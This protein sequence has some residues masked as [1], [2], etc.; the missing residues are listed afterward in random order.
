MNEINSFITNK[1]LD[2]DLNE[3]SPSKFKE[4]SILNHKMLDIKLQLKESPKSKQSSNINNNGNL[5]T[6]IIGK[7]MPAE[8][9]SGAVKFFNLI[10]TNVKSNFVEEEIRSNKEI[11][12]STLQSKSKVSNQV[13]NTMIKSF[14]ERFH[15]T[16]EQLQVVRDK[17]KEGC[18]KINYQK[19]IDFDEI[20]FCIK[21]Q[22]ETTYK[23]LK[24]KL[25]DP[26][27]KH[28]YY[29]EMRS[30]ELL[31]RMFKEGMGK[32][33]RE[34]IDTDH[35]YYVFDYNL[36]IEICSIHIEKKL[37]NEDKEESNKQLHNY[38]NSAIVNSLYPSSNAY[39][40]SY[41]AS[42]YGFHEEF[43]EL[44]NKEEKSFEDELKIFNNFQ[45]IE[46]I[47]AFSN[48]TTI[49]N[50][51]VGY[52]LKTNKENFSI[53]FYQLKQF[54]LE[55]EVLI[56]S[57]LQQR[58]EFLKF[59][60]EFW[61]KDLAKN[62][63]KWYSDFNLKQKISLSQQLD[64]KIGNIK[65]DSG[66]LFNVSQ[67]IVEFH[68]ISVDHS[69]ISSIISTWN[70][71]EHDRD[72]LN[73]LFSLK[74]YDQISILINS[75]KFKF[76][77]F[78]EE[79]FEE[80]IK[81]QQLN[82]IT[83]FLQKTS[84][85]NILNRSS[86]QEVIV[87]KYM[88]KGNTIYYGTEMLAKIYKNNWH[89]D[90]TK[91]LCKSILRTIKTKDIL[92]CHSPILTCVLLSE[93]LK[94]IGSISILNYSRID[95][96]VKELL[97]FCENIQYSSNDEAYI[98]FLMNQRSV[99]KRT[100]FQ[101][102]SDN[103]F[104]DCLKN[105]NIGTLVG[106]MWSGEISHNGLFK[107]SSLQRYLESNKL[108][109]TDPLIEFTPFDSTKAYFFQLSVWENSCSMRYFPESLFTLLLIINYNVFIYL[110][111]LDGRYQG[112]WHEV[113]DKVP[114]VKFF[115]YIYIIQTSCININTLMQICFAFIVGRKIKL[116]YWNLLE[117]ILLI[118]SFLLL[119]DAHQYESLKSI[120]DS[121]V[122]LLCINDVIVWLRI[123]GILLTF[124]NLG[125]VIRIIYLM[126]FLLLKYIFI[127][128]VF[129]VCMSA[130]FTAI[131]FGSSDDYRD[132]STTLIS[133]ST[134]FVNSFKTDSFVK[135]SLFGSIMVMFYAALSSML[136]LNLLIAV[137]S[138]VYDEISSQVDSSHRS[139]LISYYQKYKWDKRFGYMILLP[140]QV[141]SINFLVII[142]Q[143]IFGFKNK[144]KQV[145]F[146]KIVCKI[147][148]FVFYFVFI[149]IFFAIYTAILIPF[150]Y[151]K[152]L[153]S[154]IRFQFAFR[155]SQKTK[156]ELLL[157]TL[158]GGIFH[159]LYFYFRDLY[160]ISYYQ[161]QE[162]PEKATEL[163]RVKNQK[164]YLK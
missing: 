70:Y 58:T 109:K 116:N 33:V 94:N 98:K 51:V 7:G 133:L 139:V 36:I 80:V 6:K 113:K 47:K 160:L 28:F 146:N 39:L 93:V 71:L 135:N 77:E 96:V 44:V 42:Q 119:F 125:P 142:I 153:F 115:Y 145:K 128:C 68:K 129:I 18:K 21:I 62:L 100:A 107:A 23:E 92:N 134:P 30:S 144:D 102:S 27:F 37:L 118:T 123:V 132:F 81:S 88:K 103:N 114:E 97:Q 75:D 137:L 38:F 53:F 105:P 25:T 150:C 99:D 140:S 141:S 5:H 59:L 108:K 26:I 164:N 121:E 161:F 34:I 101:I 13:R 66:I 16:Q 110:L 155:G 43:K 156:I 122:V 106:K 76:W 48:N 152:A 112:D 159:L 14:Q 61:N 117:F 31:D 45:S 41:I 46:D 3:V 120:G 72:L 130:V 57:I 9:S 79:H 157:K 78:K 55:K 4:L 85:N 84:L 15:W 11:N 64:E 2:K 65:Y 87:V 104:Y 86:I 89:Q 32:L 131:F 8:S 52:C 73:N 138:S 83:F 40:L 22:N 69:K 35:S 17:L 74:Y 91:E 126:A 147:Y 158:F 1:N 20:E 63:S 56:I 49:F 60:W 29:K 163:E 95:K 151:L 82:L 10:K 54:N 90:L 136:L 50:I 162:H 148:F 149:F 67:I 143:I 111:T 127:Y 12:N 124:K 154:V 24:E 19:K